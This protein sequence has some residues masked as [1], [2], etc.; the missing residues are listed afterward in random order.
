M[1]N[2]SRRLDAIWRAWMVPAIVL[3][4]V[5]AGAILRVGRADP[6]WSH[7]TWMLGLVVAGM[8]LV[9]RTLHGVARGH[10]ATD[11]VAS[12]AILAAIPLGEPL[13]GLIVVLMQTGGE[14]LEFYAQGRASRAVRALE[15]DAPRI[16]H[17]VDGGNTRDITV[18]E[19]QVG[20]RLLLRPGE[21]VP[22][23]SVV[24]EG[25]SH[26]D[27][28]R[29]TGEPLP[30]A[31]TTGTALLS[32]SL[33]LDGALMLRATAVARDSQYARIVELVRSAQES[34]APLQRLADRYA[35]WFTPATLLV[36]LVTWIV[37]GD[38]SR[39]LAVLVVATPCPLILATPIAIVGGI[40]RAASRGVIIRNGGALERLDHVHIAVFDKTGTITVGEPS[41]LRVVALGD[42][43]DGDLL[44]L[45]AAVEQRSGHSLA[46]P[47]VE[48]ALR[49]SP[50]LPMATDVVE[51]P[52]QGVS[53]VV[54]GRRIAIG[55]RAFL[56]AL[57]KED[58]DAD[59][60]MDA[61]LRA[62]VAVD[63]R[64]AGFIDYA[65]RLRPGAHSLVNSL[66]PLGFHRIVLLSGDDARNAMDVAQS[67][68]I[69]E[70]YAGLLPADKVEHVAAFAATGLGV[71]MVGDGTNDAPALSR[72]DVG[73][74]LAGHGGGITAEAADIVVLTDDLGLIAEAVSIGRRTM[75]V[76]RESIG[77]G[78]ALSGAAM[79][80]ASLGFITPVFGALLQEAI[81]VAVILN[82]LRASAS[83][84]D[85]GIAP[86][87][88]VGVASMAGS[89]TSSASS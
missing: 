73:I 7:A 56:Q 1:D 45:A 40:N 50:A 14:A 32:G 28:S 53:G 17:R 74:A 65:D 24:N 70:V 8:P 87:G 54:E 86:S 41:V 46:R 19:I 58:V 31:A 84:R 23:D 12:L 39:M 38:A 78:L 60:S 13:A 68:G 48:A 88:T 49:Q 4:V 43:D 44:R 51:A 6:G 76:A 52:G 42:V 33:N 77:V 59:A 79:I 36:C 37:S 26:I 61:A 34:K 10:F 71:M 25:R 57:V 5:L 27:T 69:S 82:A 85:A 80:A 2:N 66:T 62:W 55:S 11:V 9:W 89:A 64:V 81:D 21:M 30:I 29:L 67:V 15:A 16:A 18:E 72:A 22:C 35:V 75:R 20:D 83:P 3:T 63:G 47:V